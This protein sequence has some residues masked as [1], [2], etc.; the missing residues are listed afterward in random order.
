MNLLSEP[1]KMELLYISALIDKAA[2]R[3]LYQADIVA[4]LPKR[5]ASAQ[6]VSACEVLRSISVRI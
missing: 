5:C 4:R 2:T 6:A 1:L 3:L